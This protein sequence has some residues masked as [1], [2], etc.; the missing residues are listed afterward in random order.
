MRRDPASLYWLGALGVGALILMSGLGAFFFKPEKS[1]EG[2]D[3]IGYGLLLVG[4]MLVLLSICGLIHVGVENMGINVKF[5]LPLLIRKSEPKDLPPPEIGTLPL[6]TLPPG[7]E[8]Y[9]DR[10]AMTKVRGGLKD[11]FKRSY[12]IWAAW[13]AGSY[14]AASEVF[15]TTGKP[16][17][18][19][20]L[21]PDGLT[22][23]GV[24]DAFNRDFGQLIRDINTT[25][26]KALAAGV[27]TYY[28]D[29]PITPMVIGEPESGNGWVRVEV[30]VPHSGERPNIVIYQAQQPELFHEFV[31][32]FKAILSSPNTQGFVG[33][34]RL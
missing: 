32:G 27:E 7:I 15:A 31:K 29:G 3:L 24:A 16:H 1:M 20:L 30:P 28:F 34:G 18:L 9:V 21:N 19:L 12:V 8:F 17:K 5:Q 22:V 2:Y 6:G 10:D 26:D 13:Y 33:S 4:G 25:K 23:R 11:E 14:A